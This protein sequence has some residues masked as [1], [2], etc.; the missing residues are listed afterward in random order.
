MVIKDNQFDLNFLTNIT[1]TI[2]EE[3]ETGDS[4]FSAFKL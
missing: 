4:F 3:D 1:S 2:D